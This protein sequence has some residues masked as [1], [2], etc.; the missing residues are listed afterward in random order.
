MVRTA[1]INI[2][3]QDSARIR[4]SSDNFPPFNLRNG[5]K[6]L[7]QRTPPSHG[8]FWIFLIRVRGLHKARGIDTEEDMIS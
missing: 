4:R 3:Y 6:H 1:Y 5:L 7:M 8:T 2:I